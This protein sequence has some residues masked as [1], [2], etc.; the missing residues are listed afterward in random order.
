MLHVTSDLGWGVF[1]FYGHA[2]GM[3][4]LS[5]LTRIKPVPLQGKC[6]K[7]PEV[8]LSFLFLVLKYKSYLGQGVGSFLQLKRFLGLM[9]WGLC[10]QMAGVLDAEMAKTVT[11]GKPFFRAPLLPSILQPPKIL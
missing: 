6:G 1:P 8:L 7:S 9:G 4:D 2:V 3:R 5:I 11:L 10:I